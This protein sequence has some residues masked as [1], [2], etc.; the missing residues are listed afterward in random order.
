VPAIVNTRLDIEIDPK[1]TRIGMQVLVY[2]P[3]TQVP[4]AR[5]VIEDLANGGAT[6]RITHVPD[7]A[8]RTLDSSLRVQV[9][10]GPPLTTATVQR[11]EATQALTDAMPAAAAL[12]AAVKTTQQPVQAASEQRIAKQVEVLRDS[13]SRGSRMR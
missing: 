9:Q 3:A 12:A 2:A 5:A 1:L 13:A 7:A 10:S 4:V 8:L 11:S 6:A